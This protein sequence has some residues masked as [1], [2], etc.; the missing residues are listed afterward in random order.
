MRENVAEEIFEEIMAVF[1]KSKNT[2]LHS[3]ETHR[4]GSKI[5]TNKKNILRNLEHL[6]IK[7]SK[8][9]DKEKIMKA[10]RGKKTFYMQRRIMIYQVSKCK[11]CRARDICKMMYK[12]KM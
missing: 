1:P 8:I 12:K 11:L 3:Q 5:N 9:K 4:I 6:I 2:G 10:A 7:L